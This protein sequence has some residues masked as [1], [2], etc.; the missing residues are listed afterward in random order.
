[1]FPLLWAALETALRVITLTT[2]FGR[3]DPWSAS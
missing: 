2:D 3:V 1:M